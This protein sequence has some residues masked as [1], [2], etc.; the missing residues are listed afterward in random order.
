M[1]VWV[2]EGESERW[3]TFTAT[4]KD[5]CLPSQVALF[6]LHFAEFLLTATQKE[7]ESKKK[8][9][10]EKNKEL[11][12]WRENIAAPLRK[13]FYWTQQ[14]GVRTAAST[15][16]GRNFSPNRHERKFGGGVRG[17]G[18]C[19]PALT[20]GKARL[21]KV[22]PQQWRYLWNV[23]MAQTRANAERRGTDK[24][25]KMS[26]RNTRKFQIRN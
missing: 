5:V 17:V 21:V 9:K 25:P 16:P 20:S 23:Q 18:N 26:W 12:I 19:D 22:F 14:R 7:A 4:F 13:S 2:G 10:K 1:E 24:G 11:H 8:K 15:R 3:T 6:L